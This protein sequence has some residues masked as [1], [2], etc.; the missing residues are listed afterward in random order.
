[1]I[2]LRVLSGTREETEALQRVLG[3]AP[4]YVDGI[5]IVERD[6]GALAFWRK[7][8]YVETGEVKRAGP[9]FVSEVIVLEKPVARSRGARVRA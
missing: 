9:A 6:T 1:V 8:G 5:G 3:G 2:E 7:L 4:R